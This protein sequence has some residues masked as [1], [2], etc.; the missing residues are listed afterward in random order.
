MSTEQNI[1]NALSEQ[2]DE[3]D[4]TIVGPLDVYP[5]N[6]RDPFVI[7]TNIPNISQRMAMDNDWTHVYDGVLSLSLMTPLQVPIA[8]V[9]GMAGEIVEEFPESL[10]MVYGDTT[11]R[12]TKRG[13]VAQGYRDNAFWRTPISIRW[14]VVE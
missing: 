1:W 12:V 13:D 5:A 6:P 9:I 10:K 14:Q 11:V 4:Y 2:V 8:E 3:L 7:M